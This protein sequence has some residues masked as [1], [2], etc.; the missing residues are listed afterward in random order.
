MI[1]NRPIHK[2]GHHGTCPVFSIEFHS[3]CIAR[4]KIEFIYTV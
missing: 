2:Y 3:I 4:E 1:Q